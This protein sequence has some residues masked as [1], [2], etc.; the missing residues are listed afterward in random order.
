VEH[1]VAGPPPGPPYDVVYLDPPYDLPAEAVRAVL[2]QLVTHGWLALDAVVVVERSTR[3][4]A[5]AWPD[6]LRA[7]RLRRYGA[8]TLWYGRA[9]GPA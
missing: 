7:D 2:A 9:A 6:G 1:V 3:E 4:T 8:G 5:W